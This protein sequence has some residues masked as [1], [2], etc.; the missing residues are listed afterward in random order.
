MR[1]KFGSILFLLLLPSLLAARGREILVEFSVKGDCYYADIK[2]A[3]STEKTTVRLC[4]THDMDELSGQSIYED[5][6]AR[7]LYNKI[8]GPIAPF[9]KAG[10][11]VYFVPAGKIHFINLAALEDRNRK[12]LCDIYRLHRL[13]SAKKFP[14]KDD[15][16]HLADWIL[17]GGMDYLANPERMIE[18]CWWCHT[19]EVQD[20]YEDKVVYEYAPD[21]S[22][23][24][25]EDGTRAGYDN[26][27]YS[28]SEIKDILP[29]GHASFHTGFRACEELFK[30]EIRRT[31]DYYILLSTHTFTLK[32][33]VGNEEYG[34]LFSGA[35]HT[36]ENRKM[37][38]NLNDGLLFD[39]EIETLDMSHASLV[40][41]AACNTG[42]GI[43]TQ[44]GIQGLQGSF[45]KAGARTL[46][47]TLWSVNDR[48]T[49]AFTNSLFKHLSKGKTKFE[50]FEA[51]R[52]DLMQ[53]E[54]FCDPVYWAPFI[55]LD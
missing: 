23:G 38:Y 22:F 20:I 39:K 19:H 33:R 15:R 13:S 24:T 29:L 36:L 31:R 11:L 43:V 37:P 3:K 30:Q 45:K 53:S 48:A 32:D 9:L 28:R 52:K 16:S 49:A 42:L 8:F 51:A 41:L 2:K 27:K 47:L 35:G 55:L 34:L 14:F 54:D 17:F 50:A 44:D 10:D 5:A 1:H 7:D 12:R 4:S 46:V 21:L 26:L 18:N 6:R 40:V 25:A